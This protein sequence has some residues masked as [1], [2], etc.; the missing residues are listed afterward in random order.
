MS[1]INYTPGQQQPIVDSEEYIEQQQRCSLLTDVCSQMARRWRLA[2]EPLNRTYPNWPQTGTSDPY[3]GTFSWEAENLCESDERTHNPVKF[4]DYS[5]PNGGAETLIW[6]SYRY[7]IGFNNISVEPAAMIVKEK[8]KPHIAYIPFRGTQTAANGGLDAQYEQ[9]PN[10]I[11]ILGGTVMKGFEKYF[12]GCGI[13]SDGSRPADRNNITVPGKTL[14]QSLY[15]ISYKNGGDVTELIVTGHSMGS[16]TATL[17]GAL[18]CKM[19]WFERV[20]VSVSASPRVG[21]FGF[22]AWYDTLHDQGD[23]HRMLND[24]TYRLANIKDIVP[25]LP[26]EP[27]VEVGNEAWFEE[28]NGNNHNPCCTYSYAINHPDDCHNPHID[29]CDFPTPPIPPKP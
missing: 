27:Y 14:W 22:K 23:P 2:G 19:G 16:T 11:D 13:K 20:I 1:R 3:G 15:D 25:K 4:K 18:A 17:T 5:F 24:R 28:D 21:T 10:P 12:A 26:G 6:S 8:G 9:V 29:T 7:G